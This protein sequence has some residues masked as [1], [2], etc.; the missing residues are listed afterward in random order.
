MRGRRPRPCRYNRRPCGPPAKRF[1]RDDRNKRE[2]RVK[3][4]P[5]ADHSDKGRD[6][7]GVKSSGYDARLAEVQE[8]QIV[9]DSQR[10]WRL[11]GGADKQPFGQPGSLHAK[12]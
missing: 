9:I 4:H 12:I 6:R 1:S 11:A 8:L 7:A 5:T 10:A 2:A 3:F